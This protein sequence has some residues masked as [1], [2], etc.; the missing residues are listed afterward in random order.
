MWSLVTNFY[1]IIHDVW[2]IGWLA[3]WLAAEPHG[4]RR[5]ILHRR[6]AGWLAGRRTPCA[7]TKDFTSTGRWLAGWLAG[8]LTA[9]PHGRG[10]L[11]G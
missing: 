10:Y 5:K 7:P 4:R 9:E 8:W 6:A 1:I 11:A 2:S 3:G